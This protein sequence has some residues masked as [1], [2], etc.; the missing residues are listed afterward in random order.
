MGLRAASYLGENTLPILGGVAER[1]GAEL[2]VPG[3]P[4]SSADARR[5]LAG[6]D[7]PELVWACGRLTAQLID[8]GVFDAEVVAAPVFA[9]QGDAVY[10]SVV[11]ARS[12]DGPVSLADAAGARLAVNEPESWSGHHALVAHLRD[13]GLTMDL[14]SSVIQTG[15]HRDSVVAVA[16]GRADVA[17][18]DHTVWE[19]L[20]S[21][22]ASAAASL[23]VI[24]RS[25]DWPAPPFALRRS[26]SAE[27]RE[28]LLAIGP[29][30]VPGL[31]AVV[32]AGLAD[33]RPLLSG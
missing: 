29:G 26:V 19:H 21:A 32:P 22:A 12:V 7:G 10:H 24:D 1:V 3:R 13:V 23:A 15:S 11:L 17:A 14:F 31:Q 30:N 8:E 28:H 4:G 18:V 6:A 27:V 20:L 33:Y 2:W 9:G 5:E 25:A 16:E